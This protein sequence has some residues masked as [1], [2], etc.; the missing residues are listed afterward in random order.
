MKTI[1]KKELKKIVCWDLSEYDD[2][3]TFEV[4]ELKNIDKDISE[5]GGLIAVH[6]GDSEGWTSPEYD[7]ENVLL[8]RWFDEN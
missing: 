6:L 7:D 8:K 3:K 1:T 2:E 5:Y 4:E